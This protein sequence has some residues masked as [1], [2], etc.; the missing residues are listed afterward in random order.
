[1]NKQLTKTVILSLLIVCVFGARPL[2]ASDPRADFRS[3]YSTKQKALSAAYGH[4]NY[5]A[6]QL[7]NGSPVVEYL[8]GW[9]NE[10]FYFVR[11]HRA[12]DN[13]MLF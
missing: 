3:F 8:Q 7:N 6:I 12:R 2:E 1:M 9:A 11:T 13:E 4:H 5:R 10:E